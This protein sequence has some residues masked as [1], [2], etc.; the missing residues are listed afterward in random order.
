MDGALVS[1]L[2]E[3]GPSR[4]RSLGQRLGPGLAP[5][6]CA[7]ALEEPAVRALADR[8][9]RTAPGQCAEVPDALASSSA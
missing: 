8:P 2:L 4:K 9:T 6:P 3:L 5:L 1:P 7:F